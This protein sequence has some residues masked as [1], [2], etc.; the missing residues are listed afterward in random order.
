MG[1]Y[2]LGFGDT[3]LAPCNSIIDSTSNA[4]E[5]KELEGKVDKKY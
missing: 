2:S 5:T 1:T 3:F 4:R